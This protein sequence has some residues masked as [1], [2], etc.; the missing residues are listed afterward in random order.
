MTE[1]NTVAKDKPRTL[2]YIL[3]K[4]LLIAW[5][6]IF[7]KNDKKIKCK[8]TMLE[9]YKAQNLIYHPYTSQHK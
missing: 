5:L 3:E 9:K 6:T 8:K 2:A 7:I 4:S 1:S